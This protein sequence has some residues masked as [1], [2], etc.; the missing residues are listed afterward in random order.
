MGLFDRWVNDLPEE[1]SADHVHLLVEA[2]KIAFSHRDKMDTSAT[3]EQLQ[4]WL[5]PEYL[6]ELSKKIDLSEA[7]PWGK[8]TP[9]VLPYYTCFWKHKS[10]P[11]FMINTLYSTYNSTF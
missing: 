6:D 1:D 10:T 9:S 8:T 11:K 3:P 7:K 4:S 5:E 2:T